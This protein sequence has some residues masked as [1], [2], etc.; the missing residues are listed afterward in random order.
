MNKVLIALLL[1]IA[2]G[3]AAMFYG[4]WQSRQMQPP[5]RDDQSLAPCPPS[6]N[7]VSS[8]ASANSEQH[9]TPIALTT[10]PAKLALPLA[11]QIIRQMGGKVVQQ[12]PD[13]I[14]ATF[15]SAVFGFVDD[16]Q[17]QW[18]PRHHQ[19]DIR[20]ASR[21]GH[22]DFNV[23]RQRVEQFEQALIKALHKMPAPHP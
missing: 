6:P 1:I 8:M 9:V 4:G 17:L 22:S 11:A 3:L 21:V 13:F 20:S 12:T 15:R 16:F 2:M 10:T 23:N 14:G 7:C 5:G 18:N 19:L